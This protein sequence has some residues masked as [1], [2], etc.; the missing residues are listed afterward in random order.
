MRIISGRHRGRI[1]SPPKKFNARPTTDF[2]KESLFN[3][4][5]GNFDIEEVAVLDLFSG[6]GS[7]TY[8][9]ASR[10]CA[11]VD[12]VENNFVHYTFIKEMVQKLQLS[13]VHYFYMNVFAYLHTCSTSYDIIFADP[14]YDMDNIEKVHEF[15]ESL[16][17]LNIGGWLI[18]EH[19]R[20]I[21][22][23]TFSHFKEQ[24]IYGSVNFSFFEKR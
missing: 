8:E 2:A 22:F 5:A 13:Q 14:P 20:N 11:K 7:I 6:T 12:C 10:G 9:F 15:C 1:I 19:S 23:S 18:I 3:I 16:N 21:N 17:L 24:R 4:I